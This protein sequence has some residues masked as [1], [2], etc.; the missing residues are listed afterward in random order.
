MESG[1]TL[2]EIPYW[3]DGSLK[4]ILNTIKQHRPD[5]FPSVDMATFSR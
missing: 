4:R 5:L 3:W 2:I 1:I